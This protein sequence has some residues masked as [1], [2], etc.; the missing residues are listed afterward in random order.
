MGREEEFLILHNTSLF[1]EE[2]L[3]QPV[4]RVKKDCYRCGAKGKY[5]VDGDNMVCSLGCYKQH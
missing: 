3:K 4:I 5:K 1:S 2:M